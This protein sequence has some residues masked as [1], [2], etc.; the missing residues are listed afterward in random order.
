MLQGPCGHN[1]MSVWS[2]NA[3]NGIKWMYDEIE[4]KFELNKRIFEVK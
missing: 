3:Q 1:G 2:E 4:I